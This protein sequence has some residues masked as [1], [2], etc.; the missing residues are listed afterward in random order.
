LKKGTAAGELTFFE[1]SV[2]IM[3]YLT[4]KFTRSLPV[5]EGNIN[6]YFSRKIKSQAPCRCW[7]IEKAAEFYQRQIGLFGIENS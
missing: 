3:K 1:Q 2:N 4:P 5:L 6:N 7:Y